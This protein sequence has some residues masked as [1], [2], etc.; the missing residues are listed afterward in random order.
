M[1]GVGSVILLGV[2]ILLPFILVVGGRYLDDSHPVKSTAISEFTFLESSDNEVEVLFFGFVGCASICPTSLLKLSEVL[3]SDEIQNT[4][5][6]A[7]GIFVEVDLSGKTGSR[8]ADNYSKLFS[9]SIRGVH[10]G[11]ERLDQILKEFSARVT[12]NRQENR[13]ITHTDHFYILKRH[14][15][16]WQIAEVLRNGSSR[17]VLLNAILNAKEKTSV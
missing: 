9:N 8:E 13:L 15:G 12:N 5:L 1:N 6:K 17:E 7:G 10:P 16:G 14:N 11:K 3:E 2:L 4:G